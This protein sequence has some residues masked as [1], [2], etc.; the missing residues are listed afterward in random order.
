MKKK[1]LT[2]FRPYIFPDF[3][4]YS[5]QGFTLVRPGRLGIILSYEGSFHEF[6]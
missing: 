6:D 3:P 2:F 5:R 1:G 4:Y